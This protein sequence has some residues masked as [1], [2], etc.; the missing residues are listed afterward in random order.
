MT[1]RLTKNVGGKLMEWETRLVEAQGFAS[2]GKQYYYVE[3]L[4]PSFEN[5]L[6]SGNAENRTVYYLVERDGDSVKFYALS[7]VT[8]Q[9]VDHKEI[10][11]LLS[12][13]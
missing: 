2:D 13:D 3:G 10:Q 6:S 12:D 8:E 5:V 9:R 4:Y 1:I 7:A 11:W